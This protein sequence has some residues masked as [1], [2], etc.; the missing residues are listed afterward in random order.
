MQ[1]GRKLEQKATSRSGYWHQFQR[2]GLSEE[3]MADELLAIEIESWKKVRENI[4][5]TRNE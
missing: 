2:E 1:K 5:A 4:L 3:E